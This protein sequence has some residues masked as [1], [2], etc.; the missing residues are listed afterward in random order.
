MAANE[1][2]MVATGVELSK[3]YHDMAKLVMN[4][5]VSESASEPADE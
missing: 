5:S 3:E 1:A 4:E 2:Q